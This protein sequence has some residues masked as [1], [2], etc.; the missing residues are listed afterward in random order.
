MR[1]F[2]Y[3]ITVF[4]LWPCIFIP[5]IS[6]AQTSGSITYLQQHRLDIVGL[7]DY[8]GKL[9]FNDGATYYSYSNVPRIR[10]RTDT[11][12]SEGN[13]VLFAGSTTTNSNTGNAVFINYKDLTLTVSEKVSQ[14]TF[15]YPDTMPNIQWELTNLQKQIGKFSCQQAVGKFRGRIYK[16]WFTPEIPLP[17]GPWKLG[18][19]PG[20]I[21]EATTQD[22]ELAFLFKSINIPA[23][24]KVEI[25][26]PEKGIELAG[27]KEFIKDSDRF[28]KEQNKLKQARM[29]KIVTETTGDPNAK[30]GEIQSHRF[31][32]EKNVD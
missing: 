24:N 22:K 2:K 8:I 5:F 31:Y 30:V 29:Q 1:K 26:A 10:H 20:L 14:E 19:L 21:L 9:E 17:Y 32:I 23:E 28:I 15:I 12:D 25:L 3:L 13:R 6:I 4:V 27:F 7:T 16:V 11:I 18:G